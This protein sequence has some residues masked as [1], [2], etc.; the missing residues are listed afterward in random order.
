MLPSTVAGRSGRGRLLVG[1]VCLVG[2]LGIV[3]WQVGAHVQSPAQAAANAGPPVPSWITAPAQLRPL[4]TTVIVRGSVAPAETV[5]VSAPASVTG[6]VL[7]SYR[8][9]PVGSSVADGHVVLEISGRPVFV[10]HGS[11]PV[12][13]TMAPGMSGRDISQLQAALSHLGCSTAGDSGVFG[14]DTAKCVANLY[15]RAGYQPLSSS[16]QP[17][18]GLA[19]V[20]AIV[21]EGEIIYAP[22][23]PV[24]II[25][26]GGTVPA[27]PGSDAGNTKGAG[28][29]ATL[30]SGG[31]QVLATVPEAALPLL[32]VGATAELLDESLNKP[33]R[34]VVVSLAAAPSVGPDGVPGHAVVLKTNDPLPVS[35]TGATLRVTFTQS[36]TSGDV[37][38]VP[39]A[40]VSA[41]VTGSARVQILNSQGTPT[42]VAVVVG[43]S[44]DGF[45]VVTPVDA[46]S[47]HSGDLVVVGR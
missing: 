36:R 24:R 38:V 33:Y 10:M 16:G 34:A 7:I 9:L 8:P 5:T 41:S 6:T 42:D 40:A 31:L 32:R 26:I 43:L 15:R 19:G 12:F 22:A 30:A 46:S 37:L 28:G 20:G 44:A 39:V 29:L 17:V 47:L 4:S 11:V 25:S 27:A 35:Q 18:T 1:A 13:R 14:A 21:P 23:S 3:A 2:L 45:V